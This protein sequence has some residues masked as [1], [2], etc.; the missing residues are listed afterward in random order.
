MHAA[1]APK[2]ILAAGG[3]VIPTGRSVEAQAYTAEFAILIAKRPRSDPFGRGQAREFPGI[4]PNRFVMTA[5]TGARAGQG[6]SVG[7]G[8]DGDFRHHSK[9]KSQPGLGHF[10]RRV[11]ERGASG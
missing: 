8:E 6:Q 9:C 1:T 7:K 10:G 11:R 4:Q 2:Q 5:S 3:L